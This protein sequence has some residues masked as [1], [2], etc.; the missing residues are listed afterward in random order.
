MNFTFKSRHLPAL[1]SQISSVTIS[2]H[3]FV[4]APLQSF[5]LFKGL[6]FYL[7]SFFRNSNKLFFFIKLKPIV[8]WSK[9]LFYESL[10]TALNNKNILTPTLVVQFFSLI[11][12]YSYTEFFYR[13][14]YRAN[15][16]LA[17]IA[18]STSN[19]TR[20]YAPQFLI[21]L[22]H[23]WSKLSLWLLPMLLALAVIYW[24]LVLRVLTFNKV[25][26]GWVILF[27][28]FYW[29]ISGFV[30][31]SKSINLENTPALFSVFENVVIFYFDC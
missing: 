18:S 10:I 1:D 7:L 8:K 17:Y 19:K 24:S 16:N 27:M 26:I 5:T 28:M 31:F 11:Y 12:N 15:N 23:L 3:N 14:H 29:L 6:F 30:F 21:G 2:F 13:V 22:Q 9:F 20:S 25:V 4:S